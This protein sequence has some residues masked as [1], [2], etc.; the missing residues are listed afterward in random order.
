MVEIRIVRDLGSGDAR[1]S[2]ALVQVYQPRSGNK[3]DYVIGLRLEY[4]DCNSK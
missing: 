3:H 1:L 2:P 4:K